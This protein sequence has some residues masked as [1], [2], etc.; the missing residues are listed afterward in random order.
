MRQMRVFPNLIRR[1]KSRLWLSVVATLCLLLS[2]WAIATYACPG[3]FTGSKTH[4]TAQHCHPHADSKHPGLCYEHC[5]PT[6][7][8]SL[9]GKLPSVPPAILPASLPMTIKAAAEVDSSS[10]R[11]FRD[12][13]PAGPPRIVQFCR[14]LI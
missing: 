7:L 3:A 14:Y 5:Y 8:Q 6:A 2:Q 9:G 4:A 11:L 1:R 12:S 10:A 13:P